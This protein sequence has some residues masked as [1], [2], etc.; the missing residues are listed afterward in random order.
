MIFDAH[1][2][3]SDAQAVTATAASTN[4]LDLG[5]VRNLGA[6]ENLYVAVV[7]DVAM[8]D[9]GSD[10]TLTVTVETDDNASFS[11]ATTAQTVG[12]FAALSAIGTSLI[13]RLS[14]TAINERYMRLKY[15][16]ANGDLST[17]SFTAFLVKD[18]QNYTS[19]A[20]GLTIS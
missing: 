15:T 1:N 10:S 14:P 4:L 5:A 2:Q 16:T 9:S 11:S 6:G 12:T 17:G 7:C 20:D 8:T 19:Y 3:F 18:V 13:A